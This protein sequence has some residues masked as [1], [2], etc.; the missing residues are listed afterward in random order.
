MTVKICAGI[1]EYADAEGLDRCLGTLGLDQ[2]DGFDGAI[3]IH[4]RFDEFNLIDKNSLANTKLVAKKYP[5]VTVDH[6]D[7]TITQVDARSRY[8]WLAGELGY[9]WLMVID[10]DEYVLPNADF[11]EFRRQLDYVTSLGFEHQIFDIDFEGSL[12]QRGPRPRLFKDPGTIRYWVKHWWFVLTKT[13]ILLKGIGDA[14]RIITGINLFHSKIIRS[15]EHI[16][17]SEQYYQWQDIIEQVPES[18]PALLEECKKQFRKYKEIEERLTK[19][20]RKT[21]NEAIIQPNPNRQ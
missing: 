6:S 5:N 14:G 8:C 9:D 21:P 2:Q 15:V 4:R 13:N 1:V 10:T 11:T 20:A 17:A 19:K 7:E 18:D 12:S 3:V 16:R